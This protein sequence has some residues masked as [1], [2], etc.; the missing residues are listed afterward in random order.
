MNNEIRFDSLENYLRA[1][2]RLAERGAS[3]VGWEEDGQFFINI[4]GV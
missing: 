3:F 1:C 2:Y 4:R